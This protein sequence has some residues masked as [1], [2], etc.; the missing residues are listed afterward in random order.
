[1]AWLLTGIWHGANW[2]FI[3]WGVFYFVFQIF[4]KATPYGKFIEKYKVLG[5]IYTLL[6]VNML[7]V[8]FR[9]D[10]IRQATL[11][12]RTMLGFS[13]AVLY[14][15]QT[16]VYIKENIVYL[17]FAIVLA[18]DVFAKMKEKMNQ[19]YNSVSALHIIMNTAYE[20]GLILLLAVAIV[21][22]INGTYNP[23]IY[24]HF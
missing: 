21:Y 1:M 6:V 14:T 11:Y 16:W 22:I 24:F 20:A 18:T 9:A 15:G 19:R 8:L 17:A 2:T 10:G 5:H 13:G 7:W 23:F 12:I 4:E 3:A